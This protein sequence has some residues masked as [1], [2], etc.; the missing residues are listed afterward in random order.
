VQLAVAV[1]LTGHI[2]ATEP[3]WS[4]DGQLIITDAVVST[5]DG[6]RVTVT[7]VGGELDG[8]GQISLPGPALLEPGMDVSLEVHDG[9]TLAG[10]M[11]TMVD[12]V[13]V[14]A[15]PRSPDAPFVREGPTPAGNYLFWGNGCVFMTYDS[16]G[17]SQIDGDAEF[18]VIDTAMTTWND[19]TAGC[20]YVQLK[21]NGRVSGHEI[22]KD[23]VNVIKF[24]D[25]E[26]CTK[27]PDA[28]CIPATVS[29]AE[30]CHSESAA[31]ITTLTFVK[32]PGNADDGQIVDAD[33]EINGMNFA[34]SAGGKSNSNHAC[35]AD[36]ANTITHELGHVLGLEHT[37][38][39]RLDATHVD[40]PRVDGKGNAVP[41]CGDTTDPAI[42]EATMYPFQACG[43]TKKA[44]L[45][46]DDTLGVCQIYPIEK[47][48]KTCTVYTQPSGCC[49]AG[50]AG[51]PGSLLLGALV[52]MRTRRRRR[53]RERS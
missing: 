51:A 3:H 19:A 24:R 17:T 32:H 37:C 21:S 5:D 47:D 20:S 23:F 40:P 41:E 11:K 14:R 9:P 15:L 50:G 30:V 29:T 18:A 8:Y 12:G 25:N 4:D 31:G 6:R 33:V 46:T 34:I 2:V 39:V 53:S 36:L 10:D 27:C 13:A 43:E 52:V 44:S 22:G 38:R 45:S 35:L 16:A 48:P 49:D 42:T 1:V 28:W 26:S 7:Q